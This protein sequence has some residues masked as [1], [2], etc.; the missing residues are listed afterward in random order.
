MSTNIQVRFRAR[1]GAVSVARHKLAPTSAFFLSHSDCQRAVSIV[2]RTAGLRC[3]RPRCGHLGSDAIQRQRL[4][5]GDHPRI[6]VLVC[7][8]LFVRKTSS[9][10]IQAR[11]FDIN[12]LLVSP[13]WQL[14]SPNKQFSRRQLSFLT[15]GLSLSN[16]LTSNCKESHNISDNRYAYHARE[17]QA[18]KPS[19]GV[20]TRILETH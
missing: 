8:S 20:P 5:W 9:F 11:W 12:S 7:H 14:H 6:T 18:R 10:V 1:K 3:A 13:R 17:I 4:S 15:I 16:A 2:T 19:G